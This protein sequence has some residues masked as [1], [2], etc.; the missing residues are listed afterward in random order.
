M[1][2]KKKLR[3]YT[4]VALPVKTKY[5]KPKEPFLLYICKKLKNRVSSGDIIVFSEKALSTAL[6]NIYDESAIRPSIIHKLAAFLI[7]KVLWGLILGKIAKLKQETIK[8]IKEAPI[9]EVSAH[10][11]LTLRIGGLL[12]VLKP[13]SEAGVDTSNVPYTYVSLPLVKCSIAETL[14][15]AL[16]K[17]LGK[18]VSV[19]IVDSDRV[20]VHKRLNLAL[21]SRITCVRGLRNYG[22]LSYFLGRTFRD[23]FYP[24]A[25]PVMYSGVKIDL[26]LLLEVAEVADKVRGVG[27]GRTVFEM[28]RRFGVGVGEVTWE[29]LS[30]IPHYPIVVVKFIREELHR[31]DNTVKSR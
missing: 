3:K 4:I 31:R 17:C 11:A 12:Q 9:N 2:V 6:N 27:A 14:R 18:N 30:S 15:R 16:Q 22:V 29:M 21:A 19:M 13:S 20:Y 1:V 10:K 26:R 25:T 24:R 5:W 7:M 8:W 23:F 28:A